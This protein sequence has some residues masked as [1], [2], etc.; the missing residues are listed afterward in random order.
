MEF[1]KP[2]ASAFEAALAAVGVE[3]PRSAVFVGD[4]PFDNIYGSQAAGMRTALRPNGE[5]PAYDVTADA[6]IAALPELIALIDDWRAR[7]AEAR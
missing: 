1:M 4:R 6:E 5:V 2:H 7:L 3:T